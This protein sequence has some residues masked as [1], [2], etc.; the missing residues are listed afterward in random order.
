MNNESTDALFDLPLIA[1]GPALLGYWLFGKPGAVAG[2]MLSTYVF[3]KAA[4]SR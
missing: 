1:F 4:R 3:V 2:G